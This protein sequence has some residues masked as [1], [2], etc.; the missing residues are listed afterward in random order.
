MKLALLIFSFLLLSI[1]QTAF[2]QTFDVQGHRGCRGLMPENSI[3]GFLK[4][5]DLGVTTLEM[6]VVISADGKVVVS[7]DL[8]ISSQYCLNELGTK[9]SKKEEKN[10]LI[11]R[12]A[13]E[14]LKFFDCGIIGN[15]AFPEQ[16]KTSVFKP[17][18]IDVIKECE[19]HVSKHGLQPIKYNIE[20]KSNQDGDH[21]MHPEPEVFTD[22]V[23]NIL[24]RAIP[25]DRAII[26]SFDMRI[27][28]LWK[29]KHPEY[30]LSL[31]IGNSKSWSKNLDELGFIPDIYSP[32]FKLINEKDVKELHA[33]SIR[34]IPWTVNEIKDMKKI[35][36]LGVDGLITDYPN[37]YLEQ[38]SK[39]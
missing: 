18:L 7:H 23:F 31:L 26:Q 37:R 3:P 8:Y 16:L 4:A 13:Y 5:I 32:N 15:E 38:F 12:L 29:M 1:V 21:L 9:I 39:K 22:L 25:S 36:D 14:D 34:I 30:P 6:D 28:R 2:C 11:F 10:I 27:L 20:L 33:K 19:D 24:Q 17:L 35:T